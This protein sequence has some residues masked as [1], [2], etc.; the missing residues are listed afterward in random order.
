MVLGR[1]FAHCGAVQILC[2]LQ[3]GRLAVPALPA[4]PHVAALAV[5]V[6]VHCCGEG[7]S[8]KSFSKAHGLI[9]MNAVLQKGVQ[10]QMASHSPEL[11]GGV[12]LLR[13][14]VI[15]MTQSLL[16]ALLCYPT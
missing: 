10:T 16:F 9:R 3:G 15:N 8:G 14:E 5:R 12:E 11:D 6:L 7:T 13:E 4:P 1:W 2:V